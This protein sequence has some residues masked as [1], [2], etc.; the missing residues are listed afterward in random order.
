MFQVATHFYQ[1]FT[2]NVAML[3]TQKGGKL[4]G[5]VRTGSHS[6]T[7]AQVVQQI[8]TMQPTENLGRL[9][10]TPLTDIPT[11]QRWVF[12]T[13]WD[14]GFMIDEQDKLRML[15]DPTSPYT[16]SVVN[17]MQRAQDE[18]ILRAFYAASPTGTNGGST[19]AFPAGQQVGVGVGGASSNL[20]V[21]KLR[22]AK[23]RLMAAGVDIDAEPIYAAITASDHDALLNEIEVKSS[24]FNSKPVLVDGKVSS[25]LGINF[26]HVEFTNTAYSA[27][28]RAA[29]LTG[30]NRAI[31]VWVPS[32]MYLGTWKNLQVQITPRPDKRYAVQV[33]AT[34]TLGATRVEEQRVVQIATTG[35]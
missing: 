15:L 14:V 26:I 24:E 35:A 29:M 2:Q 5:T 21:A 1:Q 32:G 20:N 8:G 28:T 27:A 6:G 19:T 7:G 23:K 11:A 30:G 16:M 3:L 12:P 34:Q 13:D 31:P 4:A 25:F 33:Y 10:D 9:Q 22:E 17:A 18:V